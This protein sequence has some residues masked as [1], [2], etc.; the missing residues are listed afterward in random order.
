MLVQTVPGLPIS[1][2]E[3]AWLR[4][5]D[6]QFAQARRGPRNP[7]PLRERARGFLVAEMIS[8]KINALEPRTDRGRQNFEFRFIQSAHLLLRRDV[9]LGPKPGLFSGLS[10]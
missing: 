4:K 5:T 1:V 10:Q 3:C 8:R 7:A 6:R 2:R 9:I